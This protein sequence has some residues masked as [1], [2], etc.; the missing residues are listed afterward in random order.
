MLFLQTSSAIADSF[1]LKIHLWSL[2]APK[3]LHALA[4]GASSMRSRRVMARAAFV[5]GAKVP[6]HF[7][8]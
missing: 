4:Q 7:K 5:R 6:L 8:S 3:L 1:K 2:F